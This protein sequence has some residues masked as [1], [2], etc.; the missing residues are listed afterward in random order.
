[1][2]LPKKFEHN[3]EPELSCFLIEE[4]CDDQFTAIIIWQ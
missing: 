3:S 1:M 2:D 4:L